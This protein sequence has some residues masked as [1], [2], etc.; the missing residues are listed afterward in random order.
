VKPVFWEREPLVA[1]EHFQDGIIAPRETDIVVVICWRRLGTPLPAEKYRGAVSGTVPVTG[2]EWEFED[3]FAASRTQGTPDL[4]VY[5]KTAKVSV[6]VRD[7]HLLEQSVRDDDAVNAFFAKWFQ[8][9]DGSF[10]AAS[11]LFEH[12]YEFEELLAT[13]LTELLVR[14]LGQG[15]KAARLD[16]GQPYIGLASFEPRHAA[17]FHGRRRARSEVL[18]LLERHIH[19]RRAC[20][21]VLGSSG[22]GKSSLVK[23]GLIPDLSFA[24]T[25]FGVGA[26]PHATIKPSDGQPLRVLA[27]AMLTAL[28]SL[29]EEPGVDIEF[30]IEMLRDKPAALHPLLARALANSARQAKLTDRARALL[31]IVI[32][33]FEEL[34]TLVADT[35]QRLEF[36]R[37]L[38]ALARSGYV[39]V[40]ATMRSDFYPRLASIPLLAD[41]ASGERT[42]LLVPPTGP[43]FAQIITRPAEDVGL[44]FEVDPATGTSLDQTIRDDAAA[45]PD[46]LPLLAFVLERLWLEGR[47]SGTLTWDAYRSLGGLAGALGR[48]ADAAFAA[49][50]ADTQAALPRLL[51]QLVTTD[52]EQIATSRT[53]RLES[54]GGGTATRQLADAL[55]N[56]RLLVSDTHI[57]PRRDAAGSDAGLGQPKTEPTLRIAHEALLTHWPRA[58][59]QI[60]RD[61]SDLVVRAQ[62]EQQA[63]SWKSS[64]ERP[65]MLLNAGLPLSRAEALVSSWGDDL[66]AEIRRYVSASA[67]HA[68]EQ[69]RRRRRRLA[70]VGTVLTVLTLAASIASVVAM[71][72][73]AEAARQRDAAEARRAES[74]RIAGFLRTPLERLT[75][76]AWD[77]NWLRDAEDRAQAIAGTKDFNSYSE[78]ELNAINMA[79]VA[80]SQFEALKAARHAEKERADQLK[81]VSDFQSQMLY[82]IDTTKAGIDLMA[83]VRERFAATLERA[84][85]SEAERTARVGALRQELV[86]VNATDAS[87]AMID[88]TI[89]KP[90][91]KTIEEQ[92]KNDPAT[93]ASLRQSLADVYYTIGLYDAALPLQESAV[94]TRSRV[95]GEE[96]PDTLASIHKMGVL[97]LRLDG[98]F[99]LATRYLEDAFFRRHA[100]LGAEHPDTLSSMSTLGRTLLAQGQLDEAEEFSEKAYVTRRGLFGNEHPDTLTSMSDMGL[101]Y[102]ARGEIR[103]AEHFFSE[104]LEGRRR[105]LGED[106]PDTLMSISM[107]ATVYRS[108][109]E[110][111]RAELLQREAVEKYRRVQ[112]EEHPNTL[113]AM[114]NLGAMLRSQGKLTDAELYLREALEQ[115]RRVLGEEHPATLMVTLNLGR[116]LR[117]QGK[118]SDAIDLLAPIEHAARAF[119][120][121]IGSE[122]FMALVLTNLGLARIDLGYDADRFALAEANLLEAHPIYVAAESVGPTHDGI[123]CVQG[124]VDLYT[125]WHAAKPGKGYDAKATEWKAKLQSED[126]AKPLSETK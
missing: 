32:D 18:S 74:E 7:R 59:E 116:L 2:T 89:L 39:L 77:S 123:Q 90:A 46:S 92:F 21:F 71:G 114:N 35:Q 65:D 6:D 4:L 15:H 11:H 63:A 31:L 106:H 60:E 79:A 12:D 104:A 72:Q 50:A 47:Q 87:A 66:D 82:Q 52:E 124:L 103:E 69:E 26:V 45:Q 61:R 102:L 30:V 108:L 101:L 25:L 91:I 98:E 105:V 81:K 14:R 119:T 88:R 122:L 9:S 48:H 28:P 3:A 53:I 36:V 62:L 8:S 40:V 38:D 73:R 41:L 27:Q 13:H 5:R 83:D 78:A 23:A 111:D 107:M 56:A 110:F 24:G 58:K 51:R 10:T 76:A 54:L 117:E 96:H 43:E 37:A 20:L 118:D 16:I 95:L 68:R 126:A 64:G 33:Q 17:I 19:D 55:V 49:L 80:I 109:G 57:A 112:G 34:F 70:V 100:L 93:D 67:T 29:R 85:I 42:Y 99:R 22:S 120:N 121:E 84:G 113:E 1:T 115:N 75:N 97:L 94:A 125:A 44:S 86:R